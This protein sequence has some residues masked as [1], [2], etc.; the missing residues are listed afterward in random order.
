MQTNNYPVWWDTTLTIFN[1]YEDPQT[2]VIRWYKTIVENC[3]WKYTGNKINVG[4]IVLETNNTICRI[5]KDDRYLDKY[6]WLSLP[7][8]T[9]ANYF[10]LS[11]N[12]II[13]K[14][15]VSDEI[16]EYKSG[17]RSSDILSK[18]KALQ[19]CIQIEEVGN[20]TGIGRCDEHYWVRGV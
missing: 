2:Y 13:I 19:G 14:G 12:D 3:F 5:P 7:N 11:Q 20:N 18:Y 16:N 9:M 1:R 4:E 10:T 17:K 6:Q 15:E 8:D